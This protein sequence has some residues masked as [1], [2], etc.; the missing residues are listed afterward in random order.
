MQ[1]HLDEFYAMVDFACPVSVTSCN[2]VGLAILNNYT[3]RVSAFRSKAQ[4]ADQ[5]GMVGVSLRGWLSR[6]SSSP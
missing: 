5:G 4:V 6:V 1:N 3:G 2:I